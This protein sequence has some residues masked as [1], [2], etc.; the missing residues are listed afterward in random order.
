MRQMSR[1][2]F[3]F[4]PLFFLLLLPSQL[5]SG[6]RSTNLPEWGRYYLSLVSGIEKY[7]LISLSFVGVK[8]HRVIDVVS[9]EIMIYVLK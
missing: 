7:N 4:F 5:P 6:K 9:M 3:F 2:L 1:K 8:I